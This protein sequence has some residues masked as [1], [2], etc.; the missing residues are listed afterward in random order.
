MVDCGPLNETHFLVASKTGGAG[1]RTEKDA[2]SLGINASEDWKKKYAQHTD[3]GV[4]NSLANTLVSYATMWYQ[5][6][7]RGEEGEGEAGFMPDGVKFG[8]YTV[9][10]LAH[11]SYVLTII[12]TFV[13]VSNLLSQELFHR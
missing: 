9:L 2:L 1:L 11:F 13:C 6:A 12:S 5:P 8:T 3:A 10:T 4:S 7:S